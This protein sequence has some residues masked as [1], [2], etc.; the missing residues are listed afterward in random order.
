MVSRPS[1]VPG[2]A[3][4]SEPCLPT[5]DP[6]AAERLR[7][8]GAFLAERPVLFASRRVPVGPAHLPAVCDIE[9]GTLQE[10]ERGKWGLEQALLPALPPERLSHRLQPGHA[11]PHPYVGL[12]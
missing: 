4:H 11:G 10:S 8:A 7:A 6:L 9:S 5:V 12:C 2:C 1:L 3:V